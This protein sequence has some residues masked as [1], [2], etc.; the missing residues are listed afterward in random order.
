MLLQQYHS[1]HSMTSYS[2]AEKD[3]QIWGQSRFVVT[4]VLFLL[5]AVTSFLFF[6]H[7]H[8]P[9]SHPTPTKKHW[10]VHYGSDSITWAT[11]S[12]RMGK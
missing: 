2:I 7:F 8:F 6:L 1:Q 10:C 9:H 4:G 12:E 5:V 3:N 11:P